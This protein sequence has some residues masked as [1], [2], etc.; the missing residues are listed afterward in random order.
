VSSRTPQTFLSLISLL[1]FTYFEHAGRIEHLGEAISHHRDSLALR[2][3][4][5]PDRATSLFNLASYP[6][7]HT[8]RPSCLNSLANAFSTRFEYMGIVER[9][10][11]AYPTAA[12]AVGVN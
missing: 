1:P 9:C 10:S 2:P 11:L 8:L 3:P 7:G 4:G 5:H 6:P 12:A